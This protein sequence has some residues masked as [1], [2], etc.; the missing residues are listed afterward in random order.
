MLSS[1]D[2]GFFVVAFLFG[3]SFTFTFGTEALDF[4][5]AFGLVF[6]NAMK[7]NQSPLNAMAKELKGN[8]ELMY[9]KVVAEM[10]EEEKRR[11]EGVDACRLC[12][13]VAT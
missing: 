11:R 10:K 5:W 4:G 8:F 1:N 2:D 13:G 3:P 12:G 9:T 6:D 7:Y